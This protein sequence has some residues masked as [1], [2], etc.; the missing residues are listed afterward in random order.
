MAHVT[1]ITKIINTQLALSLHP[2]LTVKMQVSDAFL[3]SSFKI[4]ADTLENGGVIKALCVP[5]GAKEFSNTDL[6]K[7]T[8]YTEASKAGAKGLPF[9]KVMDNGK[10]IF[11]LFWLINLLSWPMDLFCV[12]IGLLLTGEL[13]GIGPLVSSL[14]P[15]KKEQLLKHLDAKSGDLILFALGEQSAANRILGRLRLFIAHKLEVIDTVSL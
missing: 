5:G 3:G 7:G 9:L 6:K 14:K 10:I 4:F 12:L 11:A 8:V 13:E 1:V 15:E 2:F